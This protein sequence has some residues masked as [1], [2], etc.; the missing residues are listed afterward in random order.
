MQKVAPTV[1][2]VAIA[3]APA[4]VAAAAADASAAVATTAARSAATEA[5]GATNVTGSVAG[6]AAQSLTA[7]TIRGATERAVTQIP[8]PLTG[9]ARTIQPDKIPAAARA[10]EMGKAVAQRNSV[11]SM[12]MRSTG[13]ALRFLDHQLRVVSCQRHIDCAREM[14][15]APEGVAPRMEPPQ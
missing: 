13:A 3:V 5:V 4:V 15:D 7:P 6:R 11:E 14:A 10:A 9:V 1:A 8:K 12:A 2:P